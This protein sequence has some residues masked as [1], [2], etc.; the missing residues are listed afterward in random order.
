MLSTPESVSTI[1][2]AHCTGDEDSS[3]LLDRLWTK[4]QL[5][6]TA[7]MDRNVQRHPQHMLARMALANHGNSLDLERIRA[8]VVRSL[9]CCAGTHYIVA[10]LHLAHLALT[11]PHAL[12]ATQRALLLAPLEAAE[13]A[14]APAD[15]VSIDGQIAA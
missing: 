1:H 10:A 14:G 9:G 12:S 3:Q 2:Q 4:A 6:A 7:K 13:I 8:S 11:Y 5:Q 15:S